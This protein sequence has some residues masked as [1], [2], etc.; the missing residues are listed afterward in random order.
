MPRR[1]LNVGDIN[2]LIET[3]I[4]GPAVSHVIQGERQF[5]LVVRRRRD[6]VL[7]V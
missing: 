1:A 7:K 5:D 3:G 4:G 2:A 6:H